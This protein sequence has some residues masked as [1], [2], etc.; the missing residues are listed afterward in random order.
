MR[1]FFLQLTYGNTSSFKMYTYDTLNNKY[2]NR[3]DLLAHSYFDA[4][5]SLNILTFILPKSWGTSPSGD[6]AHI[7]FDLFA[8]LAVTNVTDT[9]SKSS[10]ATD[11]N[12]NIKSN[13][14]GL[15][16]KASFSDAFNTNFNIDLGYRLMYISPSS[17][18]IN[19]NQ[20]PQN[21]NVGSINYQ[22][23]SS[24]DFLTKGNYPY[25]QFEVLVSYNTGAGG[26]TSNQ[27]A[28]TSNSNVFLKYTYVSNYAG[29][30]SKHYANN[31]FQFQI[32]YVLDISKIFY[33]QPATTASTAK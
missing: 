10:P 22:Q 23:N 13:V 1:N 32:G 17:S 29:V 14:F 15:N 9:F 28:T 30:N 7:Y 25:N 20:S 19:P 16:V 24:K 5:F 21:S 33:S 4:S 18:T 12:Y 27:S 2:V 8:S 6:M 26:T 11:L 3:L 31:Y